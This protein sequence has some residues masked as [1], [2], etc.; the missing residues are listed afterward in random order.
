MNN[1]KNTIIV[2]LSLIVVVQSCFLFY[3]IS[4]SR[5]VRLAPKP[6]VLLRSVATQKTMP[7]SPQ[8]PA[9]QVEQKVVAKVKDVG[10]AVGKIALVLDDWGYNLKNRDFITSNDYH[11]SVSILPF[12][13][14][15]ATI[16][17]LAYD[18]N[19]DVIVHIPME[20]ESKGSY[21]LE[22]N[23]LLAGMGKG[24]AM[25]ILSSALKDVPYAKGISNHMGSQATQDKPLMRIVMEF[26]KERKLFFLDSVVT[27]KS[28]AQVSAK[29]FDV[30][31]IRRNVFIDNENDPVYI[32]KQIMELARKARVSGAAVGIGHDRTV[33][34]SVLNEMIPEL[35]EEGYEFVNLSEIINPKK[36]K[37]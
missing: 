25:K 20:P 29:K 37:S 23:T 3:F 30:P 10:A 11:V 17:K 13:A 31:F 27:P 36:E 24:E 8:P 33:T 6:Q 26:L 4:S 1:F 16:A 2:L 5:R 12:R 32:R 28:I 19:K 18:K 34:I 22:E 35:M 15:S 14:Y 9:P 21:H 7:V